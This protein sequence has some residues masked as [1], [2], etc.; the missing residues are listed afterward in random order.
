[1]HWMDLIPCSIAICNEKLFKSP[2]TG[3]L[4][5]RMDS[6]YTLVIL[7][8]YIC[9]IYDE[10]GNEGRVE[11]LLHVTNTRHKDTLKIR[12]PATRLQCV[13]YLNATQDT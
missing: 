7:N 8:G 1:M 2:L 12:C 5:E 4:A 13:V 3:H 9:G 10:R 6:T 11:Y